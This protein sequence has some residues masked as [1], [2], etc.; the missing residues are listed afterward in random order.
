MNWYKHT[1]GETLYGLECLKHKVTKELGAFGKY[2]EIWDAGLGKIGFYVRSNV[3][4]TR[5]AHALKIPR[6][7]GDPGSE[8]IYF[9]SGSTI[10]LVA[11]HLKIPTH[12]G[13]QLRHTKLKT[14]VS[15]DEDSDSQD[16][17]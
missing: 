16:G 1:T 12:P 15:V 11:T 6:K 4:N 13:R 2:G 7:G 9:V 17:S 3:I 14:Q 5:L 8:P 10:A